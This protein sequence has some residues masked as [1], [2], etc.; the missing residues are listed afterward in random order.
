MIK[1]KRQLNGLGI[2]I[3]QMKGGQMEMVVGFI[4]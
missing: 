4:K 2:R 1:Q 3:I